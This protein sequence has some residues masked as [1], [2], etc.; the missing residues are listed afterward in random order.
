MESRFPRSIMVHDLFDIEVELNVIVSFSI[1]LLM[2]TESK[3]WTRM[4][5]GF[6]APVQK[7]F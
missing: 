7:P 2:P 3:S 5:C 4:E 6:L 1:E